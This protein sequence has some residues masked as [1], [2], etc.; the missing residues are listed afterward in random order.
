MDRTFIGSLVAT[1]AV[2]VACTL[3]AIVRA[4]DTQLV[5]VSGVGDPDGNGS[6]STFQSPALNNLGQVAFDARLTGTGGGTSDDRGIFRGDSRTDVPLLTLLTIVREGQS[7]PDGDGSFVSFSSSPVINGAGQVVLELGLTGTS[8]GVTD[9]RGIFLGDG[10][11]LVS[12]VREGETEPGGN[13]T[14]LSLSGHALNDAGQV[15]FNASLEGIGGSAGYEGIFRGDAP[16]PTMGT[17]L[18][19]IAR[20]GEMA[21]FAGVFD[22]FTVD[23]ALND[24]G[25]VAF[26]SI[27]TV[28]AVDEWNMYRGDELGVDTIARENESAP[29]GN[30]LIIDNNPALNDSGQVAFEAVLYNTSGGSANDK[31]IFRG[32]GMVID[33]IVRKGD[34]APDANGSFLDF[35]PDLALNNAGQVAFGASLAAAFPGHLGLFRGDGSTVL[36]QIVRGGQVAPD[37]NGTFFFLGAPAI[38]VAGQ[39]AFFGALTGTSGAPFDTGGVFLFDDEMGLLTV[40]RAGDAFLGSTITG[41][42]FNVGDPVTHEGSGLNDRGE[43][44]YRFT[45]EDGRQGIAVSSVPEPSSQTLVALG[46]LAILSRCRRTRPVGCAK[47]SLTAPGSSPS[48]RLQ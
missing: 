44:A 41:L 19:T 30:F 3:P 32:D 17:T 33:T 35:L 8:G 1:T 29:G 28:N 10:T 11:T 46:C 42:A 45:L 2:C 12:I 22:N 16:T 21:P 25:Q 47:P 43:V 5:V 23:P 31:G 20:T 27:V 39:V 13:G 7:G 36:T 26:H 38:N 18:T 6:F 37:G 14:F 9:D 4:S 24:S 15:A 40:A 48:S 34:A